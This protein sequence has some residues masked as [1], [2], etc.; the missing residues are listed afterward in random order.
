M[1]GE[2]CMEQITTSNTCD[3]YM[4]VVMFQQ[5]NQ[6]VNACVRW[7]EDVNSIVFS[8]YA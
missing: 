1:I 6:K 5:S 2:D 7:V 4:R 3:I 8:S